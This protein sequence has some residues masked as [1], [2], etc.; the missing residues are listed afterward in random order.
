[1]RKINFRDVVFYALLLTLLLWV[2]TSLSGVGNANRLAYSE[3]KTAA[4]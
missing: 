2:V 1:M 3:A 4:A